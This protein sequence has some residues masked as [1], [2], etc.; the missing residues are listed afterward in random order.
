M[1]LPVS[2]SVIPF[3]CTNSVGHRSLT[4]ILGAITVVNKYSPR[5][6]MRPRTA[7]FDQHLATLRAAWKRH[8]TFPSIAELTGILG[9]RSTGGVFKIL[10]RMVEEGLLERV[11][12]RLAPTPAFFALPLVGPARAGLPQPADVGDA[13]EALSVE[14][15]LVDH[16][17]RTVYC[18]VKGESMIDAGLLDGDIVVVDRMAES[19]PGD[20]VVAVIDNQITVK[21][22]RS[23][24]ASWSLEP[25]N[26][27]FQ[28]IR[29]QG[30]L[31]LLGVVVGSFRRF[32][33]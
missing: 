11:G 30:S 14:D 24:G 18:R 9:L 20:I 1:T 25:A 26:S 8:K 10:N 29:P 31:E 13:P 3:G 21:R 16:P 19:R 7:T 4:E 28:V 15:F 2:A 17:E 5:K 6:S 23:E 32:K 22:L 12:R 27:A 33:R